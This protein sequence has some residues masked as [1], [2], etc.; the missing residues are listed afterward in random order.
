[1]IWLK[2][3]VIGDLTGTTQKCIGRVAKL[4]GSKGIDLFVTAI[5]DGVHSPGSFHYIGR[6][7][8]FRYGDDITESEIRLAAGAGFDCVFHNSHIHIEYDPKE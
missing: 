7:F 3:G 1:M 5:R 6:A 4:Y 8:D 2:Q